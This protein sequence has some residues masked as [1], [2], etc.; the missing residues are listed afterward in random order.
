MEPNP[1]ILPQLTDGEPRAFLSDAS[2]LHRIE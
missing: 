1:E 2:M